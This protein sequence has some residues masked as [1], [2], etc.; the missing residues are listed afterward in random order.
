MHIPD[1]YLGPPTCAGLY[2]LM[3]PVWAAAS[4]RVRKTLQAKQV[5]MLAIGAAFSFVIMMF[6]VPIIG[7]ST[8]H[9]VGGVLVAIL[10][11]PWAATIAITV[12]LVIQALLFGDGGI[13]AL[14]ANCFNMAFVLPFVG[15]FVYRVV[16]YKAPANSV[17]RVLAAGMAGYIGINAAALLTGVELGL[18]TIWHRT[19]E[20]LALY[21]P[22]SLK[23]SVTAMS[24][25]HLLFFGWVEAIVTALVVRFVRKETFGFSPEST[26]TTEATKGMK[27]STK[28]WIGLAILILLSPLGIIIPALF[29]AGGAWGEWSVTEIKELI[30]YA[31]QGMA[32]LS[33]LWNPPMPD[34]APLGA[35]GKGLGH[36]SLAYLVSAIVGV[37]VIVLLALLIGK[38]LSRKGG[39]RKGGQFIQR[40]LVSALA[41]IK[42]S[43]FAD[44]YAARK[45]FLQSLD[46]RIKTLTFLL[47]I[48]LAIVTKSLVVLLFLYGL[49][50]LLTYLSKIELVFFLKR[51][52]IFIPLFSIF[53]VIPALFSVFSPGKPI[54]TLNLFLFKLTITEQGL[55]SAVLFIMRV[56]T[57]VS[58]AVLLSITTKHFELLKVLRVFRIPQV[59]VMIV[60]MCYR[61]IFLFVETVENTY[62]AIKSRIGGRIHYR[63]GQHIVAWNIAYLW[64]RSY[65]LNEEVYKAMRSRGYRG[66][67]VILNRF[68]M[69]FK[70][71]VWLVAALIIAAAVVGSTYLSK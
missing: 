33:N 69:R 4:W 60:G 31:P 54:T 37:L 67:P 29:G 43:I 63:Q 59:F 50:L 46:P 57:S 64:T 39:R 15:Y 9:A 62:L 65:Q 1:G 13:M 71:L 6:N 42:E 19:P 25:G 35:E 24:G 51:T 18:Q 68:R 47:F 56:A 53:V 41:F 23:A 12:A 30:G 45:G 70:D 14:G 55:S 20:G 32:Q 17:R 26:G 21:C 5:P 34:Y 2:A 40:S 44:E 52:W 16:S 49:S 8:G 61:Y 38:L 3:V 11:G 10:L 58:F 7:S 66:E 48:V 27:L 36:L 28:L 22:Y